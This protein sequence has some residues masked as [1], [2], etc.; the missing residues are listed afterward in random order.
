MM[1]IVYIYLKKAL[2]ISFKIEQA[3]TPLPF[4]GSS[5][6]SKCVCLSHSF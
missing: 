5:L 6:V 2:C 1:T 3:E 4:A